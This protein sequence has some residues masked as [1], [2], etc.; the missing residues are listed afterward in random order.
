LLLDTLCTYFKAS[1]WVSV[2]GLGLAYLIG[3]AQAVLLV[4]MLSILEISLSFDNA[5]VNAS[6]MKRMDAIWRQRFLTWGM[7]IAVFGMRIVLPLA[8]VSVIADISPWTA[9]EMA[10]SAPEQYAQTLAS[11][12]SSI[13]GFGGSFL[14]LVGLHFFFD[15]NKSHWVPWL[16]KPMAKMANIKILPALI[17][18]AAITLTSMQLNETEGQAFIAASAA[19]LLS[20]KALHLLNHYLERYSSNASGNGMRQQGL[21]LFI[22][23]EI[24]DASFSFDGVVGAFAISYNLWIIA[25]G[26]GIGAMFVRSLTIMLV[27]K[28][29]L[30]TY[31]YLEHGAFYAIIALALMMFVQ[32]F[33]HLPEV[34][35]G[36][37]SALIIFSAYLHSL[38]HTQSQ[39]SSL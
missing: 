28:G 3:G 14:L 1:L 6:T 5:V 19:G 23:L 12:H 8:F 26:L 7:L 37:L 13:M 10:H 38:R 21:A 30:D 22:Y 15:A 25:I 34:L 36:S 32:T 20:F 17:G 29:S 39:A 18:L 2:L 11:A 27:D 35:V 9:F 16:E 24:L 31:I 4:A 33:H